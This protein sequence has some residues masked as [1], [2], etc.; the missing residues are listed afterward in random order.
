[1]LFIQSDP[2]INNICELFKQWVGNFRSK[3][4]LE[5]LKNMRL[6]LMS[7][8]QKRYAKGCSWEG[9]LTLHARFGLDKTIQASKVYKL[10]IASKSSKC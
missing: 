8:L 7:R 4:I 10:I 2:I 9:K 3:P 5:L 1:M 6:K